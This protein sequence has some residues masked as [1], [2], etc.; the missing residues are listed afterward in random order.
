VSDKTK[1]DDAGV[2]HPGSS[3]TT[4]PPRKN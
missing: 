2:D 1:R 4:S 3:T